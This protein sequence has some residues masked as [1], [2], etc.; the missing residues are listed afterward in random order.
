VPTGGYE[1]PGATGRPNDDLLTQTV[2]DGGLRAALRVCPAQQD[3]H[4]TGGEAQNIN[5]AFDVISWVDETLGRVN[6]ALSW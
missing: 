6:Q 1:H 3:A 5:S 4:I 2:E